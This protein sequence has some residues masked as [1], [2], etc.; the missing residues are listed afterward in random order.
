[1]SHSAE[2]SDITGADLAVSSSGPDTPQTRLSHTRRAVRDRAL[3]GASVGG[4][5]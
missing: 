5:T 4:A 1:M 2:P 3:V